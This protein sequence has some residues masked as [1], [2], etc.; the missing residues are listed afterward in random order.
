VN[1]QIAVDVPFFYGGSKSSDKSFDAY[2]RLVTDA[3]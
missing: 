3:N 2:I 1:T